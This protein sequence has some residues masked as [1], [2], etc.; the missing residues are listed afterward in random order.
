M[1]TENQNMGCPQRNSTE[2]EKYVEAS[3]IFHSENGGKGVQ[4]QGRTP[5]GRDLRNQ[6]YR[7][8]FL[9]RIKLQ[10][11]GFTCRLFSHYSWLT[12]V[13]S[14]FFCAS[15]RSAEEFME[16]DTRLHSLQEP[17]EKLIFI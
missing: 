9:T 7:A 8:P 13:S 16:E 15:I 4:L 3:S 2:C 11:S 1:K 17:S 12:D 10:I 5:H 6:K 14:F